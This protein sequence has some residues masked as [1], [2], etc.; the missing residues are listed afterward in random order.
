MA[1][2]WDEVQTRGRSGAVTT[3]SGPTVWCPRFDVEMREVVGIMSN[4]NMALR[5]VEYGTSGL[6]A[7][8]ADAKLYIL[9]HGHAE[10]PVFTVGGPPKGYWTA[11]ELAEMLVKDG[12]TT[13]LR[14]IEMMVCHA[15]QSVNSKLRAAMLIAVK[16]SHAANSRQGNVKTASFLTKV[17]NFVSQKSKGHT[18]YDPNSLW[19]AAPLG[20]QLFGALRTRGFNNLQIIA[21][22]CPVAQYVQDRQVYLS[23]P[24]RDGPQPADAH[25]T[26]RRIW[27]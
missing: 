1:D 5:T 11:Q 21:Y 19:Q 3:F 25:P 26:Y 18:A 4:S 10:M 27:R 2:E 22:A 14:E 24:G 7:L 12:L 9:C 13:E 15:G 20:A 17:F 6:K 8:T 23:I 16:D